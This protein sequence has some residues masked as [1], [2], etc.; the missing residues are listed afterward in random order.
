MSGECDICG[1]HALECKCKLMRSRKENKIVQNHINDWIS[2]L[3][4]VPLSYS[5][6]LVTDGER[7]WV[8]QTGDNLNVFLA[9][10]PDY[11]RYPK[12]EYGAPFLTHSKPTHWME[13]PSID[14][15]VDKL[16]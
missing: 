3:D 15:I 12:N 2:L 5:D 4:Y 1:K 8:A 9:S 13:L 11:E 7:C 14:H 16:K 10:H 6:V